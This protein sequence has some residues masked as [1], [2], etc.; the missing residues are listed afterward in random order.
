MTANMAS[1]E[2]REEEE[3]EVVEEE[4]AQSICLPCVL[5]VL[6]LRPRLQAYPR[7]FQSWPGSWHNFP[8]LMLFYHLPRYLADLLKLLVYL[9]LS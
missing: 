3:K 7:S 4:E 9:D 6:W 5:A 2:M 8:F 1:I